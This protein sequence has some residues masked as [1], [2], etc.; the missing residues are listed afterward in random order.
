MK[1]IRRSEFKGNEILAFGPEDDRY[2]F[3]FGKGKAAKLVEAIKL[4]GVDAVV[5]ELFDFVGE[6]VPSKKKKEA[7]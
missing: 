5:K 1:G 3:S 4:N 2:P 7:A 6:E